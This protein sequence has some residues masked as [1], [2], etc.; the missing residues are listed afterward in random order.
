[1]AGRMRK[2]PTARTTA[3]PARREPAGSTAP[4]APFNLKP[5]SAQGGATITASNRLPR[6]PFRGTLAGA[7][8]DQ[9]A[10]VCSRLLFWLP[11][12]AR[13]DGQHGDELRTRSADGIHTGNPQEA[14]R[15]QHGFR[16]R[17]E[18]RPATC[19]QSRSRQGPGHRT[20]EP[21]FLP[22]FVRRNTMTAKYRLH[23]G[24][25]SF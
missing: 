1:M 24:K 14:I 5:K 16:L 2:P 15:H 17:H 18:A 10:P 9:P 19:P 7:R 12:C 25:S 13:G 11:G 20:V 8:P 3:S 21:S 6:R 4:F 23:G 22:P